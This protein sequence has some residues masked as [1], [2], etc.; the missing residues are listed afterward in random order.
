[1]G[2]DINIQESYFSIKDTAALDLFILIG[3]NRFS[4]LVHDQ[5]ARVLA[6]KSFALDSKHSE[7]PEAIKNLCLQEELLK[8]PYLSTKIAITNR[9][10]TFVPDRLF[11]AQ[12]LIEYL[13]PMTADPAT[14]P[15]ENAKA[16]IKTDRLTTLQSRN[17]YL[18]DP[19]L[20][21]CL[22][23]YFPK[24]QHYHILSPLVLGLQQIASH[25]KGKK[26][27]VHVRNGMAHAFLFED[28][29]FLFANSFLYQTDTDFIYYVMLVYDQFQLDAG[30]VP[31]YY[32]GFI[33][34]E[35]KLY[36]QLYRYIR[37]LHPMPKPL[38][39]KYGEQCKA[40]TDHFFFDLFSLKLCE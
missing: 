12:H 32:S 4:L 26:V 22:E 3:I 13:K 14:L 10:H 6:L 37:Y 15:T 5:Q 24:A 8:L 33:L 1:M 27:F 35:A 39:F 23:Q 28:G 30:T 36:H 7:L 19:D 20:A 11:D 17:V 2:V 34:E 16:Y 21:F 31:L 40:I 38:Y 25:Q 9:W 18:I 29:N